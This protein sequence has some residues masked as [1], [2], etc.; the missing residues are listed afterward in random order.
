M[1]LEL[2]EQIKKIQQNKTLVQQLMTSPD[3]QRL[4]AMLT[5]DARVGENDFL[6]GFL[7]H[8]AASASQ[9]LWINIISF[10]IKIQYASCTNCIEIFPPFCMFLS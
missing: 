1:N 7:F 3:G 8:D 6:D 2:Q 9:I 5:K 4:L 10:C